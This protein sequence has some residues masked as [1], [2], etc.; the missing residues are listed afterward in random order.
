MNLLVVKYLNREIIVGIIYS[1]D[2]D[3]L[4]STADYRFR[5][6]FLR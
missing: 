3:C 5:Y 6:L 4:R 1:V 2:S